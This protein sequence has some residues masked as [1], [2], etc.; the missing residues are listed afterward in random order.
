MTGIGIGMAIGSIASG[1]VIDAFGAQSGFWISVAA[2]VV[3]IATAVLGNRTLRV[4]A[5]P[6]APESALA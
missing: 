6:A 2:G 4:P 3:A 5:G 1:Y